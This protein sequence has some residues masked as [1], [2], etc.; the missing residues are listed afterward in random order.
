MHFSHRARAWYWVRWVGFAASG[1]FAYRI[2]RTGLHE[3][4]N[5]RLSPALKTP[6]ID[7]FSHESGTSTHF[8]REARPTVAIFGHLLLRS[9][10]WPIQSLNKKWRILGA[11][12][13][14][15][16]FTTAMRPSGV[17]SCTVLRCM[18]RD[19]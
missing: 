1:A 19:F 10:N 13:G 14:I 12:Q 16:R 11:S 3:R 17:T 18:V 9:D 5:G 7:Q 6:A 15:Q 4:I 8:A 2:W